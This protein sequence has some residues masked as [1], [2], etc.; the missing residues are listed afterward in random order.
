M[1]NQE[2]ISM[3]ALGKIIG[4]T[5]L[6]QDKFIKEMIFIIF[7]YYFLYKRFINYKN[8]CIIKT[9]EIY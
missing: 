3:V 2:K 6:G 7:I 4:D 5:K 9:L 8:I 1:R